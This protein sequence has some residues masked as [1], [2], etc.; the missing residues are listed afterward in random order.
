M[1]SIQ[2]Y[3]FIGINFYY[4]SINKCILCCCKW[5]KQLFDSKKKRIC[6]MWIKHCLQMQNSNCF[7]LYIKLQL[8]YSRTV[9]VWWKVDS[10]QSYTQKHTTQKKSLTKIMKTEKDTEH[11]QNVKNQYIAAL[12]GKIGRI[13]YWTPRQWI[14]AYKCF[15]V[16]KLHFVFYS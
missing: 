9:L 14:Y 12:V 10:K 8:L 6:V 7:E 15:N 3:R 16:W 4:T 11:K 13:I 5:K 1:A 2:F